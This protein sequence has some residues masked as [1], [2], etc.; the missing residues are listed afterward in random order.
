[1][2]S[3]AATKLLRRL[4][5]LQLGRAD[6]LPGALHIGRGDEVTPAE[7]ADHPDAGRCLFG[8]GGEV[9]GLILYPRG[10]PP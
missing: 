10:R 6:P 1:M 7:R 8:G 5:L 3:S 9:P 4:H 2:M